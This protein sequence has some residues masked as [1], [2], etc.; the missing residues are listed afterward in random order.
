MAEKRYGFIRCSTD[1]QKCFYTSLL[2]RLLEPLSC[3]YFR[4]PQCIFDY[5]IHQNI[6]IINSKS[7]PS[8]FLSYIDALC[9]R[10]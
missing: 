5:P 9:P 4:V 3:I 8:A 2:F 1:K 10:N 7:S 6:S